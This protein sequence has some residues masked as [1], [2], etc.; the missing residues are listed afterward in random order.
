VTRRVAI[1]SLGGTITMTSDS[2]GVGVSPTLRASEMI[3]GVPGLEDIA[4]LTTETLETLPGASLDFEHVHKALVWAD[5]MIRKGHDGVV[6]SQGTDT[7]EETAY[8]FELYWNHPEP[9]VVTGA[10]RAPQTLGSDGPANLLAAVTVARD[11]ESR[12]RGVLVVMNDEIHSATRVRK[13]RSSGTNAFCSPSFGVL[14]YVEEG[15]VVF[16][17]EARRPDP[18]AYPDSFHRRRV[19]LLETHLGDRGEVLGLTLDAGFDGVVLSGFGVGHVSNELSQLVS[20]ATKV[21]PVVLTTRTG[22]GT[23]YSRTYAFAGSERDLLERGVISGG[24][25]DGRKACILLT[26]LIDGGR[27]LEEIRQEF[28]LRGNG[29]GRTAI[30]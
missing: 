24:W 12:N 2:Q 9:L 25:L 30:S 26:A 7:L 14:G 3:A 27:D 10:M 28:K 5:N 8:L 6:I 20:R 19:A 29:F 1:A 4:I 15:H 22:S 17:N 23:I 11:Q 21:L 16:G 13:I 18:L